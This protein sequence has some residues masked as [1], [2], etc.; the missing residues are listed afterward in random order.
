MN[1]SDSIVSIFDLSDEILLTIFKKLNNF[2]ALYS[3]GGVNRKLDNG[4]CDITFT[5]A[6]DL[7]ITSSNGANNSKT[8]AIFDRSWIY[9]LP[10]I[11]D[12]V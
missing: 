12:N 11:H 7:M 2:D 9:I 8:N 6:I 5:R 10:R 3:F 1:M 4:A